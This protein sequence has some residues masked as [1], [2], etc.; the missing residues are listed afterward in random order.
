MSTYNY[1]PGKYPRRHNSHVWKD[2]ARL[3]ISERNTCCFLL[4]QK[5]NLKRPLNVSLFLRSSYIFLY[6]RE[7]PLFYKPGVAK[8]FIFATTSTEQEP[9]KANANELSLL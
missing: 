7:S 3:I 6:Q 5:P 9:A 1:Q 8:I 2:E 4:F